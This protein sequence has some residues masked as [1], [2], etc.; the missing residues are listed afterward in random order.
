MTRRHSFDPNHLLQI[1]V[2]VFLVTFGITGLVHYNTTLAEAG[3]AMNQLF[4]RPNDPLNLIV[5][6]IE[7]AAGLVVVMELFVRLKGRLN[8]WL[9]LIIAAL[10]LV[11]IVA[12]FFLNDIFEP[13]FVTWLNRLSV[14]LI[15]LVALWIINRKYA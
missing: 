12:A 6:V 14:D 13:D 3:R 9:T 11:Q 8:F 4:G 5:A 10:W 1:A 7:V 2:G 15:I